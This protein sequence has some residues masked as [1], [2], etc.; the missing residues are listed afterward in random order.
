MI[1]DVYIMDKSGVCL[2]K[3]NYG[4]F[5]QNVAGSD[6]LLLTG[7]MSA[8]M[9]FT[10]RIGEA[11]LEVIRTD[12]YL[13]IC[14]PSDPIAV[15][16]IAIGEKEETL[17]KIAEE[18]LNRFRSLYGHV[19]DNWDGNIAQFSSF[20]K[21]IDEIINSRLKKQR[22]KDLL[23]NSSDFD[24]KKVADLILAEIDQQLQKIM[25]KSV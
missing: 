21:E 22:V 20:S 23:L 24:V 7:F 17:R 1:L 6:G 10:E 16:L 13:L 14:N 11:K 12:K 4:D 19:L 5:S 2:C 15:I 3:R 25:E 8:I 9:S 18:I